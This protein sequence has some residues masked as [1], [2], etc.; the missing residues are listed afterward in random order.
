MDTKFL[1][2]Q[3]IWKYFNE[4]I[5]IP[6][7][8]GKEERMISYLLDFAKT[9]NLKCKK[10]ICGNI[11]IS[12]EATNGFEHLPTVILQ[13][14]MDMV[15]EKDV[16][17][18]HNFEQDPIPAYIDKDWVKSKGT[19]LGADDGIG[20][21][22]QLA[23]LEA[24]DIQHGKIEALFTKDEESGMTGVRC[25]ES[26]FL[27]G[28]YLINLDSEEEGYIYI[29]CAGGERTLASF[30]Y[31]TQNPNSDLY[32]FRIDVTGLNGGHSGSDIHKQQGNAIKILV[33]YLDIL[34]KKYDLY[35]CSISGGNLMN[36]IP[37]EANAVCAVSYRDKEN[38][39]IALNL[40][41]A[42]VEEELSHTD[43]NF[44]MD[45]SSTDI[46]PIIE[47]TT[48][49][50]I[51]QSLMAVPHGVINMSQ[52]IPD[53]VET[54]SN[55]AAIRMQE[56]NKIEIATSQRSSINSMKEYIVS[57]ISNLFELA[58]AQVQHEDAYP[59]W[60]PNLKSELLKEAVK[61]Y[62]NLYNET[63]KV[64]AIHAG[65]ECGLI[66]EKYPYLEMISCGPTLADVHSPSERLYIPSVE[67]WWKFLLELLKNIPAK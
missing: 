40:F 25:L 23:I 6:R 56:N 9:H 41:I 19:T 60:K 15:C 39:R 38:V 50:R 10:D 37:R 43:P 45:I 32:F 30:S 20:I 66:L 67:R 31:N 29:G 49:K 7:P 22:A 5:K 47:T 42:E 44:K 64:K 65:L 12:K 13:S 46:M 62:S 1:Y 17:S 34:Q 26:N 53:L 33:R 3:S 52:D 16:S 51:L 21:A 18:T 36:A 8:S 24:T 4:I 58:G 14:H 59:G 28:K 55:L 57:S 35:L 48:S 11:L 63:I 61:C 27:S 2:P 54:S